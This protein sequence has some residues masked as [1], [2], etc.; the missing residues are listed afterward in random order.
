MNLRQIRK[1]IRSVTNVKKI[2]KA[3]QLVA[4]IKMKKAQKKAIEGKPYRTRLSFIIR[5]ILASDLDKKYSPLLTLSDINAAKDLVI[6]IS[7]NKGLCGGFNFNL[8]R[9]LVKNI[10]L[11]TT[12]FLTVGSKGAFFLKKLGGTIIAD[13]SNKLP[14]NIISAIFTESLN[15]FLAGNYKNVFL[16]YN[17][18]IN[19]LKSEPV[20]KLILPIKF[21][22]YLTESEEKFL[23]KTQYLIEPSPEK[24]ID[25]VLKSL[26]EEEIRGALIDSEAAEH[27]ARMIAMKNASENADNVVY[28]L[29][30]LRNRVRQEK[31]TYEL[32]DMVTAKESVE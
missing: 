3:M 28:N 2:T 30:L 6:V 11:K 29:T 7:S 31:I 12:D 16:V 14:E 18:F 25:N 9:F 27:S 4:S 13:F 21:E 1:K 20:K 23:P 32:L 22:E 15:L 5:K 10:D 17:R 26:V 19:T 8:F 24:I